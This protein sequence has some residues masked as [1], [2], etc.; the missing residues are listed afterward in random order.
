MSDRFVLSLRLE[1]ASDDQLA[2]LTRNDLLPLLQ[3]NDPAIR[4]AAVRALPKVRL[5]S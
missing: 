5:A 3:A 2:T 4:L 1:V